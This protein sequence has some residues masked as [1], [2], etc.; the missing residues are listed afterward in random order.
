MLV[1]LTTAQYHVATLLRWA[2]NRASCEKTEDGT[3]IAVC[4]QDISS[5]TQFPHIAKQ[6][7]INS[8]MA[9]KNIFKNPTTKLSRHKPPMLTP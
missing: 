1:C 7:R 2:C 8:E 9:A 5:Y 3:A 6:P 4:A